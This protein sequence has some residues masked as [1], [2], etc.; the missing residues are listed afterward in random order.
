MKK[1]TKIIKRLFNNWALKLFSVVAAFMLWLLVMNID[2]P[3]DQKSFYSIPVKLVNTDILEQ[4]GMVYEILDKTDTVRTVLVTAPKSVRDELSST[5]IVAEADFNNLTVT[6]TIEI[7]FYSLRYNDRISDIRGS[8]E[9]LRLN[10]EE[11]KTKRLILNVETTGNVEDGY[12]IKDVSLDQNRIE[13]SGPESAI[14]KIASAKVIVDVTDSTSNISTYSNVVLYDADGNVIQSDNLSMNTKAIR[15]NVEVLAAKMVPINYSVMGVPAEGYLFTGEITSTPD[16]VAIAGSADV[17]SSVN[18]IIVAEEALNI[19]GQT[20]DMITMID[21]GDYLPEGIILADEN[22]NGK[23]TV[24]AKIEKE[25]TK[26]L[27]L[28]SDNI[29][30]INVPDGYKVELENATEEHVLLIHG[31][32]SEVE[33]INENTI[34]GHVNLTEFMQERNMETLG[35]GTYEVEIK[36]N[37][38]NRIT[39]T[40]PLNV[41]IKI[42]K[43]VESQ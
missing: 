6:N 37:F 4:E 32:R 42:T 11:K 23:I 33:T 38:S 12:V 29:R 35:V 7:K 31:L 21:I 40:Q 1:K 5:D 15:V 13:V 2:D 26:E 9:I 10:I 25:Q 8:N 28:T 22:F 17:L 27:H 43:T 18:E 30:F 41:M 20:R 34:Y 36:F 16:M 24:T 14:S 19:T 39:I 3:E